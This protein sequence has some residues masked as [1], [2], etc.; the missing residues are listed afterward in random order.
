MTVVVVREGR[1]RENGSS[2]SGL[3]RAV[4]Q[5]RVLFETSNRTLFKTFPKICDVNLGE[6]VFGI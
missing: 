1:R 5:N 2:L 6:K 3:L 4:P